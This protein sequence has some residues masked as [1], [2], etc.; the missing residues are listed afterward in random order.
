MKNYGR[1]AVIALSLI[2]LSLAGEILAVTVGP[3][4]IEVKTDPGNIVKGKVLVFNEGEE[5]RTFYADFEKFIEINGE[6]KFLPGE[7]TELTNW[8]QM[9]KTDSLQPKERKDI[10]FTIE[11]PE[12]A[13]PGGHFAVMWWGTAAPEQKQIAIVTRAGIL[14][15]LQVS[16]EVNEKGEVLAFSP[17]KE[18]FFVF[19]LPDGFEVKFRNAGNTYLKPL[20]EITIKNLLGST[21]AVFSVNEKQRN[22][23]P[24]NTRF[25][26][27]APQFE[28]TPFAFGLYRAEL[29]LEWGEKP[30]T[31]QKSVYFFV[32]PWKTVLVVVIIL[33][34]LALLLTKGIK[35]YN[36]WIVKKYGGQPQP[37][38]SELLSTPELKSEP[39]KEFKKPRKTKT[40]KIKKKSKF[41]K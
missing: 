14:V 5:A 11:V 3:A 4:K 25:L 27:T 22:V 32:F 24:D 20:G 39:K 41:Y 2:L 18:K 34:V 23:L 29:A 1:L 36:Q 10:P 6:R 8:F 7:E 15:F 38:P 35:K 12:N 28:K 13:P 21:I 17:S 19:Q 40:K 33:L 16:G 30:G 31:F 37:E 26:E 9:E